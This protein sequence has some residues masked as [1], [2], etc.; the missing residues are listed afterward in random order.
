MSTLANQNQKP[1][2]KNQKPKTNNQQP[3][4]NNQQLTTNN[5]QPTTTNP[6]KN[7]NPNITINHF[8]F[9]SSRHGDSIPWSEPSFIFIQCFDVSMFQWV[10]CP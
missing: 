9:S 5:Q 2:T 7:P 4:T 6:N 1:K 10:I 8:L 3:T